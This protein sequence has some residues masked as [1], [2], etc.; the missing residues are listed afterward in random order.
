MNPHHSRP[1]PGPLPPGVAPGPFT[2]PTPDRPR[3]RAMPCPL[4]AA[5][6]PTRHPKDIINDLATQLHTHGIPPASM[7]TAHSH[8]RALLSL[9]HTTIWTNGHTLT[10]THH[11][12]AITWDARD[13]TG[14]AAR[15]AQHTHQPT[16]PSP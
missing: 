6:P 9:P 2:L 1:R 5:P 7:Y 14:A 15:L 8:N 13:I 4:P 10:W 11:G 3:G 16:P 12:Q